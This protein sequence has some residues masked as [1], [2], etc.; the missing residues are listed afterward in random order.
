[1]ES[2]NFFNY[3]RNAMGNEQQ[4][5]KDPQ[6]QHAEELSQLYAKLQEV[7]RAIRKIESEQHIYFGE[8]VAKEICEQSFIKANNQE[9][10]RV[11][12]TIERNFYTAMSYLVLSVMEGKMSHSLALRCIPT[13]LDKA[14]T[15]LMATKMASVLTSSL[16]ENYPAIATL[17]EFRVPFPYSE[18]STCPVFVSV[19]GPPEN[20]YHSLGILGILNGMLAE[21]QKVNDVP[22]PKILL[23]AVYGEFEHADGQKESGLIAFAI[24]SMTPKQQETT[25][26]VLLGDEA[27]PLDDAIN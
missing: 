2:S 26:A 12:Q 18:T 7:S 13:L 21:S 4:K 3:Q 11:D 14:L 5:P 6:N 22:I 20:R 1:M 19:A 10:F 24:K 9:K 23:E 17:I 16:Q 15:E 8:D 27:E 25:D